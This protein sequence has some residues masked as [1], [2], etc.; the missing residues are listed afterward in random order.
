MTSPT[1]CRTWKSTEDRY[2]NGRTCVVSCVFTYVVCANRPVQSCRH[3]Q[4][5]LGCYAETCKKPTK[6]RHCETSQRHME[7]VISELPLQCACSSSTSFCGQGT[8][9]ALIAST[10]M[11]FVNYRVTVTVHFLP[12]SSFLSLCKCASSRGDPV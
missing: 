5:Y 3:C 7:C 8:A 9:V 11:F 12:L 2:D 1:G 10:S 4:E 6:V